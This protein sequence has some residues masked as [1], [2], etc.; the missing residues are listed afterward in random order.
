M[1]KA[2]FH[3]FEV[4]EKQVLEKYNSAVKKSHRGDKLSEDELATIVERDVLPEWR[5]VRERLESVHNLPKDNQQKLANLIEYVSVRQEAW[6]LLVQGIRDEDFRKRD[7]SN[8]K[9]KAADALAW[10]L[11]SK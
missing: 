2:E 7:L 6:E 11:G 3:H 1:E 4:V 10:K 9:Q 8:V 5:K